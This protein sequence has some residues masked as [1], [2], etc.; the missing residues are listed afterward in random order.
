MVVILATVVMKV[1][2]N[3]SRL[4]GHQLGRVQA[5]YAS[6]AGINLAYDRLMAASGGVAWPLPPPYYVKAICRYGAATPQGVPC[7]IVDDKLPNATTY[8]LIAVA[9][10]GQAAF[11][12]GSPPNRA[13]FPACVTTSTA[14]IMAYVSYVPH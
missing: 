10:N 2:M 6:L 9:P 7:A 13:D 4:T 12:V 11:S 3:Q 5:Y 14:C 1:I 8:V